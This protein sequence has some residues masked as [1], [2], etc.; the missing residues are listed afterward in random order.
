MTE[1]TLEHFSARLGKRASEASPSPFG[2]WLDGTLRLV[3]PGH[4]VVEFLVR[5]DMTNPLGI[6]HG[7]VVSGMFD[8][9]LGMLAASVSGPRQLVSMNLHVNFLGSARQGDVVAVDGRVVRNGATVLIAEGTL[10]GGGRLLATATTNLVARRR[11]G[12]EGRR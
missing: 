12:Q 8:D 5:A 11:G 4:F 1:Y 10:E 2:R 7:G 9:V 6:L 3:E